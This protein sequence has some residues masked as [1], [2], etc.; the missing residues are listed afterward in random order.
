MR[1]NAA[2]TFPHLFATRAPF[3]RRIGWRGGPIALLA[4]LTALPL[5]ASGFAQT[6][7]DEEPIL[8]TDLSTA[9]VVIRGRYARQW[10]QADGTLVVVMNGGF[11]LD[12]GPR[13]LVADNAVLWLR[14]QR[15][16]AG[17]LVTDVTCYLSGR[18]TV[19]ESAGTLIE[20]SVL[21]VS[22]IRTSGQIIKYQDAHSPEPLESSPLYEQAMRDRELIESRTSLPVAGRET[23]TKL[24]EV[25]RP[26]E[27]A[28]AGRPRRQITYQFGN[29][30]PA[31]TSSG[32]SVEVVTGGVYIAQA[33]SATADALE[34]R[35]DNAV[36]FAGEK[37]ADV[38]LEGE[39]PAES[40][41][42]PDEPPPPD[43]P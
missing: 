29:I 2:C 5:C 31:Q 22:N 27:V 28:E 21:L 40:S 9:D 34:I 26:R 24:V 10:R 7:Y 43:T 1:R 41:E 30:E 25:A 11:R 4:L 6:S 19:R 36:V 16:D 32:E 13:Q 8:P 39:P 20:D 3:R 37:A 38:F 33:G 23:R 42:P 18:A 12:Y 35:A 15:D 14:T 17:V